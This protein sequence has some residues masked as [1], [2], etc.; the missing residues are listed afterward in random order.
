MMNRSEPWPQTDNATTNTFERGEEKQRVL[1]A[2]DDRVIADSLSMILN[3]NGFE[4]VAVHGGRQAV[5]LAQ[6]FRPDVL[7]SDVMMPDLNGIEAAV[8]IRTMLPSCRILL[9][10]GQAGANLTCKARMHKEEFE[11]LAKPIHPRRLID[12]LQATAVGSGFEV[13]IQEKRRVHDA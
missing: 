12:H 11:I 9:F 3:Q 2:D 6:Q 13:V 1:I 5:D 7:I 4:A 10:S 8:R